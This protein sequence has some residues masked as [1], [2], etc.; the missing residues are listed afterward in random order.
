MNPS[1]RRMTLED[2]P[3]VVAIDQV[4]FSLP[5]P[6]RTFRY[7]VAE[8]SAARPWVLEVEGRIAAMIV[9]WFVVDEAHIATFATHRDFRRQGFGKRLIIHAL[10]EAKKEGAKTALLEVRVS[11]LVAQ[12]MYHDLGFVESSRRS[13]YYSD[14]GEDAI[15]MTASLERFANQP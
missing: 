12:E 14:N 1:I 15:L 5:W 2:V 8:N 7:E 4:S 13:H 9:V 3:Q 10:V 11:N 6:E